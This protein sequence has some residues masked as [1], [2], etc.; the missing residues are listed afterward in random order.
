[1]ALTQAEVVGDSQSDAWL[2]SLG[3]NC[4][5]SRPRCVLLTDGC[6]EAVAEC[7]TRVID[8]AEVGVSAD[9]HWQPQGK[10]DTRE[11]QLDKVLEGQREFVAYHHRQQLKEW[12]LA[13][14]KD[15]APT[16]S[17]DIVSSCLVS[18]R[19]GLLLVEAKAH[20]TELQKDDP[21]DA[22]GGNRRRIKCAME[23]ANT[24]LGELTGGVWRLSTRHHYQLSNR[25]A[26][27]WK[28]A[29][30]GVPVVLVYLSF[31]NAEEMADQFRSQSDWRQTVIA[32][33]KDVVDVSCWSET[34]DVGGTPLLPLIRVA[35]VPF[36]PVV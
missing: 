7:L 24:S 28:L 35:E 34:L 33:S 6:R 1:M 13:V 10:R 36:Y 29:S 19:K 9:D 26:W 18:G 31:L 5:G 16:P 30:I 22:K 2:E 15:T 25:F 32:Y 20:F 11:V 4:K 12:W 17:W 21:C 3:T 27:A 14:R 23:E 8:R